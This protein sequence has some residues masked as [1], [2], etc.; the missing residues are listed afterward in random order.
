MFFF[1]KHKKLLPILVL[2][3]V[4]ITIVSMKNGISILAYLPDSPW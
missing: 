2:C 4:L 3:L 1:K